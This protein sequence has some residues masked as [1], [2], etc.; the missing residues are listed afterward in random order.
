VVGK[1][2]PERVF[3]LL[4]RKGEV[5]A[6]LIELRDAFAVA[7]TAYRAQEWEKAA[8]GFRACLAITPEDEPSKTFLGRIAHFR[9]EPP[10]ADWPG[11]W[12]L[13]TK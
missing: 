4:G 6:E 7:L 13:K 8:S 10:A 3:E 1:S 2:E 9:D 5:S 11:V 12:E